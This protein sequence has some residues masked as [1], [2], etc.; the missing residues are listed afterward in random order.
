MQRSY[1]LRCF[2]APRP[3]QPHQLRLTG[4]DGE[5]CSQ[6]PSSLSPDS[7]AEPCRA[8]PR[9][10]CVSVLT[11]VPNNA[12]SSQ[13]FQRGHLEQRLVEEQLPGR[14]APAGV[15]LQTLLDELLQTKTPV[16]QPARA[17]EGFRAPAPQLTRCRGSSSSWMA[18]LMASC[19]T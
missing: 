11:L 9:W 4:G 6:C 2:W 5:G 19:G 14:G 3:S 12:V 8:L 15:L 18:L 13:E 7:S 10:G 1:A 17:A 16:R